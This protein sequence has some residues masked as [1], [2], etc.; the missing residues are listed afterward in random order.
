[1]GHYTQ[2]HLDVGPALGGGLRSLLGGNPGDP[3]GN[4]KDE[5]KCKEKYTGRSSD[6]KID[7]L[8]M[9]SKER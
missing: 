6:G 9:V 3:R 2:L 1:M 5:G 7:C 8:K 4:E